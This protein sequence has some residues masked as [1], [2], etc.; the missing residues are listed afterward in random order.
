MPH[1]TTTPNVVTA[2]AGALTDETVSP[3][4]SEEVWK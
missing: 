4:G 2:D 1:L 3:F